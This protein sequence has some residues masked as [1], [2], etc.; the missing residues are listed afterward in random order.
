MQALETFGGI[1]NPRPTRYS[2]AQKVLGSPASTCLGLVSSLEML[3]NFTGSMVIAFPV[4]LSGLPSIDRSLA[5][6]R[7]FSFFL[8]VAEG[9]S[10]VTP[11]NTA[12]HMQVNASNPMTG[13][14]GRAELLSNLAK[15][16]SR[17]PTYFGESARPGNIVGKY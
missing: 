6:I 5:L 1:L 7:W 14:D 17:N 3:T 11:Q 2:I 12:E 4:S 16:L 15:A 13:I 8:H 10:R 9:L